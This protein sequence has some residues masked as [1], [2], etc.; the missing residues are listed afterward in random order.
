MHRQ[1][2]L[3]RREAKPSQDG[4]ARAS[5]LSKKLLWLLSRYQVWLVLP[6]KDVPRRAV[7]PWADKLLPQQLQRAAV[8]VNGAAKPAALAQ[9]RL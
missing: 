1:R 3:R 4:R 8:D 5:L 6:E 9:L 7:C 2:L